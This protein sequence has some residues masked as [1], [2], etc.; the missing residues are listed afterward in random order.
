MWVSTWLI[1]CL[2]YGMAGSFHV[3]GF[4][5]KKPTPDQLLPLL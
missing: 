1:E 2:Q 4:A 5:P 3:G